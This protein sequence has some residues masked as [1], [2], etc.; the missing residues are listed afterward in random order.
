MCGNKVK[1]IKINLAIIVVD[2]QP[3]AEIRWEFLHRYENSSLC[4]Y[5]LTDCSTFYFLYDIKTLVIYEIYKKM[6]YSSVTYLKY[7]KS[8]FKNLYI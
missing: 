2:L 1:V 7:N 3:V 8:Y 6:K 5:G 4:M